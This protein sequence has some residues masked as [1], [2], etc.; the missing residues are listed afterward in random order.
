M[1]TIA[2]KNRQVNETAKA[3]EID[4]Y[5]FEHWASS[6]AALWSKVDYLKSNIVDGD[7]TDAVV[8]T[9]KLL[10]KFSDER[11]IGIRSIGFSN[12]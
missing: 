9:D 1:H 6:E 8:D 4:K 12:S 11:T 10:E 2:Y 7:F 5:T 3:N